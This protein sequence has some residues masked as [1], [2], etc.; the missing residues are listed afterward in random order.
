[1]SGFIYR[2][3]TRSFLESTGVRDGKQDNNLGVGQAEFDS[4]G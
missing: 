4:P 2:T 3:L 1:M